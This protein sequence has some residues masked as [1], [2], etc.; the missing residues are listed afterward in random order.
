[1]KAFIILVSLCLFAGCRDN[2]MSYP[3]KPAVSHLISPI[4]IGMDTVEIALKDYFSFPEKVDKITLSAGLGMSK[5]KNRQTISLTVTDSLK[6]FFNMGLRYEGYV[7]DI[8]V[9]RQ[10]RILARDRL[11]IITHEMNGDT[12][13]LRN[14][15]IVG[16]WMVY[17]ENYKL[18]DQCLYQDVYQLCF[19]LPPE[20]SA[21]K[22]G[23][24]RVWAVNEKGSSQ[25]ILLPFKEGKLVMKTEDLD[26][27][28]ISMKFWVGK[29]N[30][31]DITSDLDYKELFDL[32]KTSVVD[33][34]SAGNEV[35]PVDNFENGDSSVF[36]KLIYNSMALRFGNY[37]P[38]RDDD[39]VYAYMRSY[40]G[41]E[42][43][44]IFNKGLEMTTLKLDLP[45]KYRNK[46]FKSLFGNRFSYGN[47][48]LIADVPAQGIE[49]IYN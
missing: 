18:P 38:L 5:N 29:I 26:S 27:L 44:V 13:L 34:T 17:W 30:Q 15:G 35:F 1:M 12:I 28:G 37:I 49:V 23:R 4:Y 36:K 9:I 24:M 39:H 40:F 11:Q 48:K 2:Q 46:N 10:E 31:Y 25:G 14:T 7:Y 19:L 6:S 47:S 20:L 22:Y 32:L 33:D 45:Y 3:E 41:L 8:P 43:I 42:W 16:Q 21:A